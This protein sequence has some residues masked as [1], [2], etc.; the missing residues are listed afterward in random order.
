MK[1]QIRKLCGPL[2]KV[3]EFLALMDNTEIVYHSKMEENSIIEKKLIFVYEEEK[4][5][6]SPP[7]NCTIVIISHKAIKNYTMITNE[8]LL[9]L[10]EEKYHV[11][12]NRENFLFFVNK[13]GDNNRSFETLTSLYWK[14][15]LL[16][17]NL[18]L[19]KSTVL[20][21]FEHIEVIPFVRKEKF[22]L[23]YVEQ[24]K[25]DVFSMF[26]E[27]IEKIFLKTGNKTL[28]YYYICVREYLLRMG[29]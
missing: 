3:M 2:S 28:P 4:I 6:D 19:L 11:L 8:M 9:F 17:E 12:A 14:Y 22:K 18:E 21:V 25:K 7:E 24:P 23:L 16:D 27:R 20:Y 15:I 10:L 26:L 1:K 13:Y 29:Y 5:V